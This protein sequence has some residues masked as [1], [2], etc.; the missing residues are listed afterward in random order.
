MSTAHPSPGVPRKAGIPQGLVMALTS[1]LP[2]LAII[3]L[4]PA[5]PS[6]IQHFGDVPH[7]QTLIPLMITAPGLM[8]ALTASFAGWFADRLGR[9]PLLLGA[10]LVYGLCGTVPLYVDSLLPIFVSRLGVGLSEA[11]VLTMANTM[12]LDYFDMR[13]RRIWLTVQGVIGPALGTVVYALSGYLTGMMWNGA[14]WI[15][16][17][18]FVLFIA[19]YVWMYEPTGQE[20]HADEPEIDDS[21]FPWGRIAGVMGLTFV[22]AVLYYIYTINGG[23]A[24]HSLDGASPERIGVMMS[25]ASLAVPL[26]GAVFGYVTR[27]I[28]SEQVLGLVMLLVGLGMIGVGMA[29]DVVQMGVSAF[30]QQIGA[31]MAVSAL[32]FWVST[33]FGPQHRGR[34]M[35][36][37]CSAFFAGMFVSPLFFSAVRELGGGDVLLP[38][39]IFGPASLVIAVALILAGVGKTRRMR[40]GRRAPLATPQ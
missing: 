1:F 11:V 2:I 24:F 32:I 19:M 21:R 35:G 26:G 22:I 18:A 7:A 14:F 28:S 23:S 37:W 15:Y 6:L 4:V 13:G 12:L 36:C 29:T 27:V 34:V 8:I 20:R 5:V 3:S 30:V 25:I 31:G 17:S 40:A 39:R 38:F 33:L 9:R 10:T 16:A